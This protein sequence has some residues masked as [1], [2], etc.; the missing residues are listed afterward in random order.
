M[1][2]YWNR[3]SCLLLLL[4]LSCNQSNHYHDGKYHTQMGMFGINIADI[5]YQ[6]NGNEITIDNSISGV[7][8]LNCRQYP[9]RIEYKENNG[10]IRVLYILK[11]GDIKINDQIILKKV[12][13]TP[14]QRVEIKEERI[15][16][17]S[18]LPEI[19]L[20]D[21]TIDNQPALIKNIFKKDEKTYI[22]LDIVQIRYINDIDF[23]IFNENPKIRTYE[24]SQ[25]INITDSNCRTIDE[26]D[27]LLKNKENIISKDKNDI[28]M[29]SSENQI[30]TDINLGCWN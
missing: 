26:N 2:N 4:M 14:S 3:F 19:V 12:S 24:V 10:T 23:K 8:K 30:L 18:S 5:D 28:R 6:I 1:N 20:T 15:P 22:S 11:N 16:L 29:F 27:Y 13:D 9:D 17:K 21:E 25:N 7:S